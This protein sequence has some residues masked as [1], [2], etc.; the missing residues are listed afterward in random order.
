MCMLYA[1][2]AAGKGSVEDVE[3]EEEIE[4][5][6]SE[7]SGDDVDDERDYSV[8]EVE[9]VERCVSLMRITQTLLKLLLGAATAL[10]DSLFSGAEESEKDISFRL[11]ARCSLIAYVLEGAV[12]DLGA[13]LYPPLQ[14]QMVRQAS[15]SLG[16]TVRKALRLLR[17]PA[18]DRVLGDEQ[19]RGLEDIEAQLT[20]LS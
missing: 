2:E 11:L 14:D 13:E 3:A 16:D 20:P 5:G 10:G 12:I 8:E 7:G 18:L 19:R 9:V 4:G 6:D 15:Q 1:L 17:T